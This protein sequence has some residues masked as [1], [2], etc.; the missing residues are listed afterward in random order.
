MVRSALGRHF[1]YARR[2]AVARR[3]HAGLNGELLHS[4]WTGARQRL[5][6]RVV[7]VECPIHPNI[8]H[9]AVLAAGAPAANIRA[10]LAR[11]GNEFRQLIDIAPVERQIHD[12]LGIHQLLDRRRFGADAA[13]FGG[14]THLVRHAAE[15]EHH[16]QQQVGVGGQVDVG[17]KERL[18]PLT[19]GVNPIE[20][21][22]QPRELVSAVFRR[23]GVERLVPLRLRRGDLRIRHHTAGS[24]R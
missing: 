18:E 6:K 20:P 19:L 23:Y 22:R 7:Y 21:D 16:I 17:L 12:A 2:V 24:D 14:N 13:G 10:A 15:F 3:R 9:A 1:D 5:L 11:T 8:G 4:V